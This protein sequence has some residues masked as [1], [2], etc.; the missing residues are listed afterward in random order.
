MLKDVP[1]GTLGLTGQSGWMNT[2]LFAKSIQHFIK[3]MR[4]SVKNP[5]LLVM[6]NHESHLSLNV[7]DIAKEN[8]LIILTFP[9]HCSHKLQHLDISVYGPLKGYYNR[10]ASE[11]MISNPGQCKSINC[12]KYFA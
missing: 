12:V 8:G 11:W 1:P 2:E 10:A 9:P 6:D 4:C 3:Y 7:Y 5:A